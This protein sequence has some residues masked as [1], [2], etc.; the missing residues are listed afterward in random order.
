M[1]LKKL[2][3]NKILQ[4]KTQNNIERFRAMS[5]QL[6]SQSQFFCMKQDS[7]LSRKVISNIKDAYNKS[8]M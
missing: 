3:L 4:I 7:L 5:Q 6:E 2:S 1:P 8:S